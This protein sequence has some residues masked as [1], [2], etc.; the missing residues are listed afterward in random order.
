MMS[1]KQLAELE[2]ELTRIKWVIMDLCETR[3]PEKKCNTL[4][5]GHLLNQNNGEA[6]THA[7]KTGILIHRK[8][9]YLKTKM[10]VIKSYV[11]GSEHLKQI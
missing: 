5:S 7:G 1:A 2:G 9:K 3:L 8:H 10:K 4:K 11:C 6:N